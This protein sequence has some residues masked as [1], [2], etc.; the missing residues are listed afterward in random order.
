M[1]ILSMDVMN[2]HCWLLLLD[3]VYTTN[4]HGKGRFQYV[5]APLSDELT[6]LV[7]TIGHRIARFLERQGILERDMEQSYL[8]LQEDDDPMAQIHED[9]K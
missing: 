2:I 7:H 6:S 3:G 1:A 9:S 4:R 5:S 8:T